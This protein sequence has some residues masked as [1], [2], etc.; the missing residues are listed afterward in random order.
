MSYLSVHNDMCV[1]A[2]VQNIPLQGVGFFWRLENVIDTE[3][4]HGDTSECLQAFDTAISLKKGNFNKSSVNPF[5]LKE[6]GG[7]ILLFKTA[8]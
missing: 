1:H 4:E 5:F 3:K 8:V 7:L 2:H 6:N